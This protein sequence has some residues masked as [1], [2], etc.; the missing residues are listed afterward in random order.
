MTYPNYETDSIPEH[1][2]S[3]WT[4][5][6]V[7]PEVV[8]YYQIGYKYTNKSDM[9]LSGYF[10]YWS[11]KDWRY[12]DDS[13]FPTDLLKDGDDMKMYWRCWLNGLP[14]EGKDNDL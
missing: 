5:I 9:T 12:E 4:T 13:E 14:F 2:V 8:G 10:W 6:K 7:N 1:L 11:G 3:H